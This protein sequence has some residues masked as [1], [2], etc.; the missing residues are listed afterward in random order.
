MRVKIV[1]FADNIAIYLRDITCINRIQVIMKLYENESTSKMN[2]TTKQVLWAGA[3]KN[4]IDQPGQI[5][6]SQFFIEILGVNF[7]NSFLHN[8]N[9]GKISEGIIRKSI[10]GTRA[11]LLFQIKR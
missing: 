11:T 7:D 8:S 3:Y 2:L 5:E 9:W 1:N 10:S 4:R 6:W